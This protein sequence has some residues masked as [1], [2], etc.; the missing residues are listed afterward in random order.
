MEEKKQIT[1]NSVCVRK[2]LKIQ[3]NQVWKK[4]NKKFIFIFNVKLKTNKLF[5]PT[6]HRPV[7]AV[8]T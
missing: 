7:N 5:P 3:Q 8:R 2:V 6:P 4:W 1:N